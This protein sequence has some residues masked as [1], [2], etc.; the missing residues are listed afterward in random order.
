MAPTKNIPALFAMLAVFCIVVEPVGSNTSSST[1]GSSTS[2]SSTSGS[3][4]SGSSSPS[5][6]SSSTSSTLNCGASQTDIDAGAAYTL[7]TDDHD[8]DFE[9]DECEWEFAVDS[10]ADANQVSI[11]RLHGAVVAPPL[12]E[13]VIR[14]R[15]P[16]GPNNILE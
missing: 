13:R 9:G 2:G 5:T 1:T 15:F 12:P 14:V 7:Q 8:D 10:G 16:V 11:Y 6:P 3:S 4:T